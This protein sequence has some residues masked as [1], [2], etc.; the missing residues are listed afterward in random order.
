MKYQ[1]GGIHQKIKKV[2]YKIT[3]CFMNHKVK[4]SHC[5]T[6]T[7]KLHLL[8]NFKQNLERDVFQTQPWNSKH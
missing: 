4:L 7:L 2:P 8:L 3:K 6:I 1:K 5:L